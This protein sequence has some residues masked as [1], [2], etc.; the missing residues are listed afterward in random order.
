MLKNIIIFTVI[1]CNFLQAST[2]SADDT[3]VFDPEGSDFSKSTTLVTWVAPE[4]H[5]GLKDILP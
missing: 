4:H 2:S 3:D 5:K 1:A